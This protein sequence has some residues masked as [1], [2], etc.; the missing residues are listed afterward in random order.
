[1]SYAWYYCQLSPNSCYTIAVMRNMALIIVLSFINFENL[2]LPTLYIA[3]ASSLL[4]AQNFLP[5]N[6]SLLLLAL[7]SGVLRLP[8]ESSFFRRE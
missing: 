6:D 8:Y 3:I 1:M 7:P 4:R 2:L 5:E